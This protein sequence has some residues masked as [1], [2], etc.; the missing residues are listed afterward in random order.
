[1]RRLAL[2]LSIALAANALAQTASPLSGPTVKPESAGPTLIERDYEGKLRALERRPEV[3]A[4]DLLGLSED[5]LANAREIV[6]ERAAEVEGIVFS[7][8]L[9]LGEIGTALEA[10]P[11]ES[12]FEV[13]EDDLRKRAEAALEPLWTGSPLV[14]RIEQALP[15]AR[16]AAYRGIVNDWYAA[17]MEQA[18]ARSAGA[19]VSAFE[20]VI[21]DV[22]GAEIES[23]YQRGQTGRDQAYEEFLDALDLDPAIEGEVRRVALDAYMKILND[24]GREPNQTE[25]AFIFRQMLTVIP[26]A[27]HPRVWRAVFRMGMNEK[28]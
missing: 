17:A 26:E 2:L 27:D 8:L 25:E 12:G 23:A 4:L 1:M 5:E 24:T 21:R 19:G 28:E 3:A 16:R 11:P 20:L 18:R 15:Q 6:A 13:L 14:D 22:I 10:A 9:L 7:N